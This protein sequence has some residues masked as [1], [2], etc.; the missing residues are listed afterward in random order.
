MACASKKNYRASRH[1]K[2]PGHA[3]EDLNQLHQ[4]AILNLN[5]FQTFSLPPAGTIGGKF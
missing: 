1:I 3:E 4:G 2:A 5:N